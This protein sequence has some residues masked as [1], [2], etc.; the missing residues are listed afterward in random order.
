V[1]ARLYT[2][3]RVTWR[4]TLKLWLT[5][6]DTI[7]HWH[8]YSC[9]QVDDYCQSRQ[10]HNPEERLLKAYHIYQH[11]YNYHKES[12][13]T[14]AK[15]S[16]FLR[17]ATFIFCLPW[18]R[19]CCNHAK[20]CMNEK[21]IQCLPNHSQYVP[22]YLQ[23][24]PSC[25]NHNCKKSPFLRTRPS[26]F[27]FALGTPLLQSRKTLHEWKDNSVLAKPLAACAH[28]FST[29][30]QL[31][32]PQVQKI[33]VFTYCSPHFCFPWRPPCDYHAICCMDGKTI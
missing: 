25:S 3:R 4:G 14:I 9:L 28:L 33:A 29:V 21:T 16:P 18:G 23:Q 26:F 7:Y 17:T 12:S 15:K 30:S 22:I 10:N 20:R 19:P 31:F 5:W 11:Y 6:R 13:T 27:L 8:R 1:L 24:F 32:E 2:T